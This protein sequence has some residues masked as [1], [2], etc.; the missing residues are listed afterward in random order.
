MFV[1]CCWGFWF[2]NVRALLFLDSGAL[3][4]IL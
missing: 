2:G 4:E 3:A 1:F